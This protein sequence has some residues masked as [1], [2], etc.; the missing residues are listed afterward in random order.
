MAEIGQLFLIGALALAV[1]SVVALVAG[2]RRR[3][4]ELVA[5]GRTAAWG[6][7][8]LSVAA[9]FILEYLLVTQDFS[10]AYV[11]RQTA[12][13]QPLFY[14]ITA[15][16]GGNAGSL[17]FWLFLL[18]LYSGAAMWFH[19]DD[20][21]VFMAYATA[22]L[23]AVSGFF[24]VLLN[25]EAPPFLSS[26][27]DPNLG[28]VPPD[29]RGLNPLLQN[30]FMIMHPPFLYGGFTGFTV[31]FA[32]AMAALL[33]K[34]TGAG[35]IRLSR[36]WT[37]V[38]WASLSI[39]IMLGGHWAYKE[40]GWGGYWAWD[41][42]ENSSLM[43]WLVATA[44]LHSVMVQEYRG[45]LKVWNVVLIM[46]AFTL[47]IF[48]T[49]LTRSGILDSIHA[50]AEGNIGIYF[51]TFIALTLLGS[52]LLLFD[53]LPL[54]R[55]DD[56]LDALLSRETAFLANNIL[57][58]GIAFAVFWGTIYPIISEAAT[59]QRI[60]VGP[61]YFN[62]VAGPILLGMLFLMGIAPLLPW[63]RASREKLTRNLV[64]PSVIGLLMIPLLLLLGVREWGVIVALGVV[65][66]VG[67]GH[68]TE[69]WRGWRAQRLRGDDSAVQ[70]LFK[71]VERNRRRYGGYIIH[72]GVIVMALGIV[73]SSFYRS[74]TDVTVAPDESFTFGRYTMTFTGFLQ[75]RDE[76]KERIAAPIIVRN[77]AGEELT[78]L[79]PA[80]DWYFKVPG[81]QRETEVAIKGFPTEDLYVV[82]TGV[83]QDG[84]ATYKLFI[85]PLIG[86]VW[87]GGLIL[88]VGAT[89]VVW[90][91]PRETRIL[92]RVRS[93][94]MSSDALT[95]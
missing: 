2:T 86:F 3:L 37:L 9:F 27:S 88:V 17:L 50:F 33:A 91:D 77:N 67:I 36:R 12:I 39:G 94:E 56:E 13:G 74:E 70:A 30:F 54:L 14:T 81:G 43:P 21:D 93:R 35:W 4:P 16:W 5:S 8:A 20:N 65:A 59:G 45:M 71:L 23:M 72:L 64:L 73:V 78:R 79:V 49:F 92:E 87:L 90:P 83:N 10:V 31:P 47:S 76:T 58:V 95:V 68:L 89:I 57:F 42:V 38:A 15:I 41:P 55:A 69:F 18:S 60:V 25:F 52:L 40:L 28:V 7:I 85:E 62:V 22:I 19:R 44:F 84:T 53:R 51:L 24:L 6:V 34:R 46:L 48:G 29:G 75:G 82:L 63:R 1:Y 32:F 26:M 66:F 61:P 11:V 80:L